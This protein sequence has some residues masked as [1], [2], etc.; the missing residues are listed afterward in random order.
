MN[1]IRFLIEDLCNEIDELKY[2]LN[3]EREKA[4]LYKS[5]YNDLLNSSMSHNSIMMGHLVTS[6]IK[7]NGN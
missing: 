2:Q 7:K 5:K 1:R 6:M 3:C 4:Q